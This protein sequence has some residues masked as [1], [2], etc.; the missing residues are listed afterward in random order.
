V[1]DIEQAA[2]RLTAD[3]VSQATAI[4]QSR[5]IAEVQAAV[6][7]AQQR[8]RN[9]AAAIHEMEDA[10]KHPKLAE[11]AFYRYPRGKD[12]NGKTQYVTGA[13]IH[14]AREL[15]RCWGNVQFN[16]HELSRNMAAG[17]SEVLA[18]AWDLQSNTRAAVIFI[19]PHARDTR[20]RGRVELP[21]L[22]DIYENNANLGA[23]R[24]REQIY[25]VLPVWFREQAMDLCNKTLAHGGGV[26][27]QQR[28]AQAINWYRGVGVTAEQLEA[29][30]GRPSNDWTDHDIAQLSVI[31][32][33]LQ[34][35]EV[36]KEEEFPPA[37]ITGEDIRRAAGAGTDD[38][39]QPDP[40]PAPAAATNEGPAPGDS[41][42][43]AAGTA[44]PAPSDEPLSR[45]QQNELLARFRRVGIEDRP[46]RLALSSSILGRTPDRQMQT[47]KDLS[48]AEA[49]KIIDTL[50]RAES[51]PELPPLRYL[52]QQLGLPPHAISGDADDGPGGE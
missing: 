11:R 26:P 42:S 12:E 47:A 52:E 7:V 6:V 46:T 8:P 30:L 18:Y 40:K 24:V 2:P 17:E 1:T 36:T 22:R 19:V 33:S 29:K 10:C 37:H 35:G 48:A 15:A 45:N 49:Q 13:S 39:G 50:K 21:E 32:T 5:A 31:R 14:L 43:D 28:V 4:E 25:A 41:A 3:R 9:V 23:R 27:L 34:R 51:N 44:E 20:S 16:V 38:A